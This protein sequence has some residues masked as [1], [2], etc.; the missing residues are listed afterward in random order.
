M[1]LGKGLCPG[2]YPS[3]DFEVVLSTRL[4]SLDSCAI[5]DHVIRLP[6]SK[7]AR[8]TEV[9]RHDDGP[10]RIQNKFHVVGV[11]GTGDMDE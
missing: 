6:R 10:G 2:Q 7:K 11:G 1:L 4:K 9:I 5:S 3:P 8:S